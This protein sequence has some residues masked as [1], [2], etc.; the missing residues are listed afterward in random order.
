MSNSTSLSR[1]KALGIAA[2]GA[3]SVGLAAVG[4]APAQA[5]RGTEYGDALDLLVRARDELME[6][7]REPSRYQAL[8]HVNMAI[9]ETLQAMR[10]DRRWDGDRRFGDPRYQ[11]WDDSR[12]RY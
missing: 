12:F 7:G 8:R 11:R 9:H 3:A 1:R 2:V 4:I 6:G 5:A 10:E